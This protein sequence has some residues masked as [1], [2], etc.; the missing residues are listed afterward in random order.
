MST[1]PE[2]RRH[3]RRKT[4][5]EASRL[6]AIKSV[7]DAARDDEDREVLTE[8]LLILGA[9]EPEIAAASFG[10]THPAEGPDT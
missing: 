10:S 7:I 5:R 2:R 6:L 3:H 4:D 9:S 1:F 8:A